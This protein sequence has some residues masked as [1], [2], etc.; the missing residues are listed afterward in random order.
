MWFGRNCKEEKARGEEESFNPLSTGTDSWQEMPQKLK[1][2]GD[3]MLLLHDVCFCFST[4]KT[5]CLQ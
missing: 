5:C 2:A 4:E 3:M 1:H